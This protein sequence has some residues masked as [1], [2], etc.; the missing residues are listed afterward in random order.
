ME[1]RTSVFADLGRFR[2][3][4]IERRFRAGRARLLETLGTPG[5]RLGARRRYLRNL[6]ARL[7]TGRKLQWNHGA[8]R[9]VERSWGNDSLV[10]ADSSHRPGKD[11]KKHRQSLRRARLLRDQS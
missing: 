9:S 11:E 10:N 7:F 8:A 5:A 6:S 3:V 2:C 1:A 4:V